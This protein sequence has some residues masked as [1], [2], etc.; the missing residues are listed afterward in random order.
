MIYSCDDMYYMYECDDDIQPITLIDNNITLKDGEITLDDISRQTD[1]ASTLTEE[2]KQVKYIL[3]F[4][5]PIGEG[6]YREYEYKIEEIIKTVTDENGNMSYSKYVEAWN[7]K[8]RDNRIDISKDWF[9][10][11]TVEDLLGLNINN[12]EELRNYYHNILVKRIASDERNHR[13][14]PEFTSFITYD[15]NNMK[16]EEFKAT[17]LQ[18]I[19]VNML[20]GVSLSTYIE[21]LKHKITKMN[22]EG[23]NVA[24][25]TL[26]LKLE[27]AF[28]NSNPNDLK[29]ELFGFLLD[30]D[31]I[32]DNFDLFAQV[33]DAFI[34]SNAT[35]PKIYA[36]EISK[37]LG[38]D[39]KRKE[40]D[41]IIKELL[42]LDAKK[43]H[44][45]VN[46]KEMSFSQYRKYFYVYPYNKNYNNKQKIIQ[47]IDEVKDEIYKTINDSGLL[48]FLN[49]A[50][51]KEGNV[52]YADGF[53]RAEILSPTFQGYATKNQ[54]GYILGKQNV[55]MLFNIIQQKSE[56]EYTYDM[57]LCKA[58]DFSNCFET[59]DYGVPTENFC[60]YVNYICEQINKAL[61]HGVEIKN[62]NK[63]EE[64]VERIC[65]IKSNSTNDDILVTV[66]QFFPGDSKTCHFVFNTIFKYPFC[67]ISGNEDEHKNFMGKILKVMGELKRKNFSN[68]DLCLIKSQDIFESK[69]E[70]NNARDEYKI[71][72]D[73]ENLLKSYEICGINNLK[74]NE[75]TCDDTNKLISISFVQKDNHSQG[76]FITKKTEELSISEANALL[77]KNNYQGTTNGLK[78]IR[79]TRD[80]VKNET[81]IEVDFDT[82]KK[83]RTIK[84]A[85]TIKVIT[86]TCDTLTDD[87][88]KLLRYP[89]SLIPSDLTSSEVHYNFNGKVIKIQCPFDKYEE[90]LFKLIKLSNS[91]IQQDTYIE[92]NG[93]FLSDGMNILDDSDY[94]SIKKGEIYRL[95]TSTK[96][97]LHDKYNPYF[98]QLDTSNKDKDI[99]VLNPI[100]YAYAKRLSKLSPSR[101]P[102]KINI[103]S[104]STAE[105]Q[106]KLKYILCTDGQS[107]KFPFWQ[108][109]NLYYKENE[110]GYLLIDR[111]TKDYKARGEYRKDV[112]VCAI[113][114][115]HQATELE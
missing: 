44:E 61:N 54:H 62:V 114:S 22:Y 75:L 10:G 42:K 56:N 15:L 67:K 7:N 87:K 9:Y 28:P 86:D 70:Y 1:S 69:E 77:T 94:E 72:F 91:D 103:M 83:A 90:Y 92:K 73:F 101:I 115:L 45:D 88:L 78:T 38:K 2:E 46:K 51:V 59:D 113:K 34:Q 53:A 97:S 35:E 96:T 79:I 64:M 108:I 8:H 41:G 16:D 21:K 31:L 39:D 76:K 93:I 71:F 33:Y 43:L 14:L 47:R 74:I 18:G 106:T 66:T 107:C 102:D 29:K 17:I 48:G 100:K 27:E 32:K 110:S 25:N 26:K 30:N 37:K 65:V 80:Q 36:E 3:D 55:V 98:Y 105:K 112:R 19:L 50:F 13:M 95:Y 85:G 57:S 60:N 68:Y 24:V 20:Y 12:Q 11:N 5:L 104:K 23:F 99:K 40:I 111:I 81:K 84:K 109:A 6:K 52:E 4:D 49:T 63:D 89:V 58:I 82:E